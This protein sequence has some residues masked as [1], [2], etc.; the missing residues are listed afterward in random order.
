MLLGS[1][2]KENLG[3]IFERNTIFWTKRLFNWEAR[4]AISSDEWFDFDIGIGLGV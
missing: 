1:S 3:I 2:S 4:Q